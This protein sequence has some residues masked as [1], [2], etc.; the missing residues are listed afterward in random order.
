MPKS[1]LSTFL[2]FGAGA[3]AGL[4]GADL[5]VEVVGLEPVDFEL[6][7]LEDLL[8]DLEL[9]TVFFGGSSNS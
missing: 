6:V 5:T 9:L 1:T 3:G 4:G 7:V 2:G 8:V